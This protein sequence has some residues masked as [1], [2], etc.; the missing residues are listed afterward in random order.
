MTATRLNPQMQRGYAQCPSTPAGSYTDT[1]V[2]FAE[3]FASRPTVFP[4]IYSTS[5]SADIGAM[6]VSAINVTNT[7]FT[8]RAFNKGGGARM[9]GVYWLAIV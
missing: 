5:T 8:V 3:P 1:A 9:P 2:T 6:T 7:G 4:S